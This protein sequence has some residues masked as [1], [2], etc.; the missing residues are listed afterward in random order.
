M[1]HLQTGARRRIVKEELQQL[2]DAQYISSDVYIQVVDAHEQYY[3]DLE[4]RKLKQKKQ[5]KIRA[6]R[7]KI[8]H[9]NFRLRNR[10]KKRKHYHRK[11][12]GAQYYLVIKSWGRSAAYWR[13]G[14]CYKYVG[15]TDQLDEVR[16]NC[17]CF[18]V[19]FGLALFTMRVLKIKKTAFAFYVLGSLFLPIAILSV[20]FFELLGLYFSFTGD[21]R[22][23]FGAAGSI[24][25]LPIYLGLADK[26]SSRLFVWFSYVSMTVFAGFLL[27]AFYLPVEG[28]YL[29]IMLFHAFLL[30]IYIRVKDNQRIA[31]F[32]KEFVLY[33]QCSLVLSTFL[34]LLFMIT[35]CCMA[36]I[37][38]LRRLFILP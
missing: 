36:L 9:M 21:G 5:C 26:L 7:M 28:F 22:Y 23:L 3:A 12:S 16:I 29:G 4:Q 20:G 15:N 24:I 11:K 34:M 27:A 37:C 18:L 1:D 30:F 25:I 8:S 32:M 2:E 13:Y 19:V 35:T 38:C 10:L 33:I 31:L 14:S 6:S 17:T